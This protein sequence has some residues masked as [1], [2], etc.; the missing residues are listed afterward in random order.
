MCGEL[1]CSAGKNQQYAGEEG[2]YQTAHNERDQLQ[3]I[4]IYNSTCYDP[5]LPGITAIFRDISWLYQ[6]GR[7]QS[8]NCLP[9]LNSMF[10]S[11]LANRTTA[12]RLELLKYDKNSFQTVVAVLWGPT[13]ISFIVF[14]LCE[15]CRPIF[16]H[17]LLLYQIANLPSWPSSTMLLLTYPRTPLGAIPLSIPSRY[18]PW[19]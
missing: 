18:I 13:D 5:L 15:S 7:S 6:L 16:C 2:T 14:W 17:C 10:S 12:I 1:K 3:L 19:L 9:K 8:I 11:V 4:H